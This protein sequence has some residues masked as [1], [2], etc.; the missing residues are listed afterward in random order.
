MCAHTRSYTPA[1]SCVFKEYSW[2]WSSKSFGYS[3]LPT[4][5]LV[6][7]LRNFRNCLRS[8]FA[9]RFYSIFQDDHLHF[10]REW[11]DLIQIC[12]DFTTASILSFLSSILEE[13]ATFFVEDDT[14]SWHGWGRNSPCL[15]WFPASFLGRLVTTTLPK[16]KQAVGAISD[17]SCCF[18]VSINDTRSDG[19]MG[20]RGM[21]RVLLSGGGF[22]RNGKLQTVRVSQ[23]NLVKKWGWCAIDKAVNACTVGISFTISQL[24]LCG[25]VWTL[26][27][28]WSTQRT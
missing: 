12:G 21:P 5:E 9:Q 11:V 26:V 20:V 4:L 25:W 10:S 1:P 19:E 3:P 23:P 17:D 8:C 14:W 7:F 6:W 16:I 22:D 2:N 28:N 27:R 24:T 18:L 13:Q 15:R